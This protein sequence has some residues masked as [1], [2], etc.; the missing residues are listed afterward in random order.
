MIE[1]LVVSNL[2]ERFPLK[3][4]LEDLRH[5][6]GSLEFVFSSIID[7]SS[8]KLKVVFD[9]V[10][11]FRVTDEGDLLKML[12]EQKGLMLTSIYV[13]ENSKYLEWFNEQS[14]HIHDDVVH[15]IFSTVEDVIDVLSSVTPSLE[16]M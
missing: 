3:P 1:R 10:H 16:A 2:S 8:N 6:S 12:Y 14:E 5:K 11:S 15:Y 13:V 9:W 7:N 4:Q